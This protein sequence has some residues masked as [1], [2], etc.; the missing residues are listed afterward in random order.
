MVI[1]PKVAR[2]QRRYVS[3]AVSGQTKRAVMFKIAPAEGV[4]PS[5]RL[6]SFEAGYAIPETPTESSRRLVGI[7]HYSA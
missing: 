3:K 4:S 1:E 2:P 6:P 5:G 7:A